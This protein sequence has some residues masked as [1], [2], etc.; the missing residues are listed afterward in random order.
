MTIHQCHHPDTFVI[1]SMKFIMLCKPQDFYF[2]VHSRIT[3]K[4]FTIIMK[5]TTH[6]VCIW[7]QMAKNYV[8]TSNLPFRPFC[9][10]LIRGIKPP[11]YSWFTNI[12]FNK[13]L[14]DPK[15]GESFEHALSA[16]LF[17]YSFLNIHPNL[18]IIIIQIQI[19]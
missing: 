7:I 18:G 2:L 15:Q 1:L 3:E 8:V 13:I 14:L 17:L 9:L 10:K 4:Q 16:Q 5:L 19:A 11:K 6:T 12:F